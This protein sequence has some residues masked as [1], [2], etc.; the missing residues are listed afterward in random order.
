MTGL[1]DKINF[2]IELI[3][4]MNFDDTIVLRPPEMGMNFMKRFHVLDELHDEL[5]D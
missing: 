2:I 4:S 3:E 5:V 1:M